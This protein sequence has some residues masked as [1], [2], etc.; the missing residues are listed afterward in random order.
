MEFINPT[1][2]QW[3]FFDSIYGIGILAG[4]IYL[5]ALGIKKS[6]PKTPNPVAFAVVAF[7]I[8]LF[9]LPSLPRYKFESE[10]L[11]HIEGK[12]W[13]RVVNKTKWGSWHE[14]LTWFNAPVGSIFMVMPN[15]PIEGGFREVLLRF[16]EKPRITM[17][18]PNCTNNTI[19]YMAPDSEG[20]FRYTSE[21]P[22]SMNEQEV[23][24]YCKYDW[25][26]EKEALRQESMKQ[27]QPQ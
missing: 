6:F 27:A 22:Q 2:I 19:S 12:E 1:I 15:T 21:K 11:S 13:I 17:S 7:F 3:L 20:L 25:S 18:R 5:A 26:K 24:I 8:L 14:P 16:E 23:S 4:I 10:S 9:T